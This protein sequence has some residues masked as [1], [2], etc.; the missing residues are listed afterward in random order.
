MSGIPQ[1]RFRL[2]EPLPMSAELFCRNAG[3]RVIGLIPVSAQWGTWGEGLPAGGGDELQ[4]GKILPVAVAVA[5]EEELGEQFSPSVNGYGWG[6]RARL[7][8]ILITT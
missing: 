5:R 2:R 1:I 8:S 4:R 6:S 7:S 3:H